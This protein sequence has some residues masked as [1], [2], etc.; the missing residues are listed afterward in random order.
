MSQDK[1]TKY[2]PRT[3]RFYI[4]HTHPYY[5]KLREMTHASKNLFN[6]A[7]YKTKQSYL[8]KQGLLNQSTLCQLLKD[9]E[10]YKNLQR[11][12]SQLP[13]STIKLVVETTNSFK[14]SMK[15]YLQK[16]ESFLGKPRFPRYKPKQGHSPLYFSYQAIQIKNNYIH[17]NSCGLHFPIPQYLAG[18]QK[19][20]TPNQ[21]LNGKEPSLLELVQLRIIPKQQEFQVDLVYE[22]EITLY[23][24]NPPEPI[25]RVA[26]IDLGINNLAT[27]VTTLPNTNPLLING[28][29]LKS[30]NKQFNKKLANLKSKA[31]VCNQQY[32]TRQ[33][34]LLHQ[35]RNKYFNTKMHQI[36]SYLTNYLATNKIQLLIIGYN[37]TWKQESKLSKLTNQTFIQIPYLKLIQILKYKLEE[38]NITVIE[39]EESYTSGTSFLDDELPTKQNYNK[40]RR[41]YRGLFQANQKQLI[42][43]DVNASYQIIKKQNQSFKKAW[44]PNPRFFNPIKV[45]I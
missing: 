35:R 10:D 20:T 25:T 9:T 11:Y 15:A 13:Q 7:L 26:S 4:K 24:Q 42:N 41:I 29:H 40:N 16:P 36:A 1:H 45:T 39:T 32:T 38:L 23:Q 33:I 18:I 22:K 3:H 27:L 14:G 5:T 34:N 43:A 21:Q 31:M 2:R 28:R 30:Y 44:I 6:Q 8:N 37:P 19:K 12:N 17:I